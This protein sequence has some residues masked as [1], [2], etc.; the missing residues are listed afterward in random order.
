MKTISNSIHSIGFST[1]VALLMLSLSAASFG[2]ASP[3]VADDSGASKQIEHQI[4]VAEQHQLVIHNSVGSLDIR[5]AEQPYV[6]VEVTFEGQRSG[7]LRR[8]TDVSN[9]DIAINQ[10]NRK[11]ELRFEENNVNARWV[12][13]APAFAAIHIQQGV[14][15]IESQHFSGNTTIKLGVGDVE[16]WLDP[17]LLADLDA[18]VGVGAVSTQGLNDTRSNRRVVSESVT[19]SG[20]GEYKLAAEVGVGDIRVRNLSQ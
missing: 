9:M 12:V 10:N 6:S 8:K 11:L 3:A 4:S 2:V 15:S 13:V 17:N 18:R 5:Y 19:A 20:N 14:G 7:V 16:I 1:H